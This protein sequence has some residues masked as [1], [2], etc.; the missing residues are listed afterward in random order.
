MAGLLSECTE[1]CEF[2]Y[3]NSSTPIVNSID[4]TSLSAIVIT[5]SGFE[6]TPSLNTVR[7]GTVPCEITSSNE[8][9][10]ICSAGINSLGTHSFEVSVQDKGLATMNSNAQ[11]TF[12]LSA[13]SASPMRS[14]TGGGNLLNVTG[15]GFSAN[16]TV[17]VDNNQCRVVHVTISLIQ[18]VI[19]P[20]STQSNK[21]VKL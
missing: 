20:S 2:T 16:T 5:G 18:C 19:P 11:I 8:T 13:L 17:T 4:T 7:I 15:S 12:E 1:N 14:T 10:L 21:M 9:T 3:L 6:S